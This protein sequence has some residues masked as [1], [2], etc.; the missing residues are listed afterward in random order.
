MKLTTDGI[1][2]LS[3]EMKGSSSALHVLGQDQPALLKLVTFDQDGNKYDY[4]DGTL[5]VGE[6]F[7]I[8]HG[9]GAPLS[10]EV[11]GISTPVFID[12][13]RLEG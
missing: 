8:Q 9:K 13:Y 7:P 3:S 5:T 2:S 11:S 1:Y 12:L 4:V 10:V 6:Q